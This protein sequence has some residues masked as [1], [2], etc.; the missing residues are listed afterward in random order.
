MVMKRN[1]EDARRNPGLTPIDD[2]ASTRREGENHESD[3]TTG[4]LPERADKEPQK[5]KQSN[6]K[7]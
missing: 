3:R 1:S 7:G 2:V 5:K 6:R 4:H